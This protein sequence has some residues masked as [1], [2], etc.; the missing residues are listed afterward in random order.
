MRGFP[1][2]I[3]L[4]FLIFACTGRTEKNLQESNE[5]KVSDRFDLQGHRGARG[6]FPENTIPGFIYALDEGVQTL[7]M[8][9]VITAD[10]Q[11]VL[12][13]EPWF[14]HEIALLPDGSVIDPNDEKSYSIYQMSY[15]EVK[16]FDVGTK[17]HPRFP[18][19]KKIPV[20]KPLLREVIEFSEA[21]AKNT[22]R[23]LPYYNI[24]TKCSPEGD[25]L[26]HPKPAEFAHLLLDVV[27]EK[28]VEGR[29]VIQSFD[30]RTLQFVHH[31]NPDIRLALLIEN[32]A[33]PADNLANLGF[34][35]HIYSPDFHLVNEDLVKFC[36][37]KGMELIPWTVNETADMDRMIR[38][39][40]D[41]LITDYPDRFRIFRKD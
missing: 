3:F 15:E 14:S 11:V 22:G 20:Q 30:V 32:T 4:L 10:S 24:E 12:S 5:M 23:P 13:H 36:R 1:A 31:A 6:L 39:G 18:E 38:L 28:G 19:Q 40:V 35:P 27:K 34:V 9:V 2:A 8:D 26:F 29:T 25:S 17:P 7:E 33:S 37:K 41:G 21:H 16:S